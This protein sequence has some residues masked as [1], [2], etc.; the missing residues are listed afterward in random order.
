MKIFFPIEDKKFQVDFSKGI[1]ISIPLI[2]NGPQ[3]NTYEVTSA[4]SNAYKDNNFIGDT[5]EGGPCNFETY[6]FTPHC[7]GTH[8]ECIGHI[9]KERVSILECLDE[10]IIPSYLISIRATKSNE[11][12]NPPLENE[13]LV[14]TKEQLTKKLEGKDSSFLKGLIIRTIP[15]LENKKER[16]YMK[17]TSPFFTVEAM[18]YIVSLGV[19]H[20]LVDIPSVD[21]LFDDGILSA[22]NIFWETDNKKLNLRASKKTIT[23]MIFVPNK[24]I[25]GKYLLNLQFAPFV[26]DASPSRPVLYQINEI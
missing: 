25:D 26:S 22:H 23:E 16:N 21:R 15:N 4:T 5:R 13:D 2:F 9:T 12:Y 1:D 6:H 19:K 7:N 24:I 14:I 18:E 20:L 17:K 11:K 10:E 3:P 8:T